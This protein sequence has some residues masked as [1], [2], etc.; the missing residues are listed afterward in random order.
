MSIRISSRVWSESTQTG[1]RKLM[2]LAIA[3][4]ADDDGRAF[5]SVATL[6]RKCGMTTRGA[7]KVIGAL[8]ADGELAVRIAAGPHGANV[9][10][11]VFAPEAT[12]G[13]VNTCSGVNARSGVNRR[14]RRGEQAFA[15]PLNRRSP[16]PSENRQEP[17]EARKRAAAAP[18]RS[19]R[20]TRLA[21]DWTLPADWSAWAHNERP[22]VDPQRTAD[23]FADY[24]RGM[25]GAKGCKADWL[26]TWRNWVRAERP[27][28]DVRQ[29]ARR[30]LPD[31]DHV[32]T[33]DGNA[34]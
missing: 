31:A 24:W 34:A 20:G 13:G 27:G 28:V 1:A 7:Q 33:A 18:E 5:P 4:H 25:P 21:A 29:P 23:R 22:D 26:A 30:A 10:Q 11:I 2:L 12:Q 8:K 9:Y 17:S 19:K 3:D 15:G 6:A 14:S 16:E 32:F